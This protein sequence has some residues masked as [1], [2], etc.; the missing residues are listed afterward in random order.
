MRFQHKGMKKQR[1]SVLLIELAQIWAQ[2]S[3]TLIVFFKTEDKSA[4]VRSL[5]GYFEFTSGLFSS[6]DKIWKLYWD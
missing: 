6:L 4:F 2:E 1:L 3:D 5:F